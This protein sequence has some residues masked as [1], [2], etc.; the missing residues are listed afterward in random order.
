MILGSGFRVVCVDLLMVFF[1]VIC[2]SVCWGWIGMLL[3]LWGVG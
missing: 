3:G 2:D 1:I